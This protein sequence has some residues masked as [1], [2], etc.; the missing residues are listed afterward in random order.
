MP[1]TSFVCDSLI[2]LNWARW[3]GVPAARTCEALPPPVKAL[4]DVVV[5]RSSAVGGP[6]KPGSD[7]KFCVKYG[8]D[9]T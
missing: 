7:D 6:M 9:R 8:D 5:K 2:V 4:A 1:K 3:R